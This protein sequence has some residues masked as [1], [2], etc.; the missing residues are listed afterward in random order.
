MTNEPKWGYAPIPGE[1]SWPVTLMLVV[2]MLCTIG[3]VVAAIAGAGAPT[4]W[5]L[6]ILNV[7]ALAALVIL[8][9]QRRKY[10][11]RLA[12]GE[13]QKREPWSGADNLPSI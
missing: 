9:V 5:V 13:I 11:Q 12:T 10:L 1:K 6:V 3:I 7:A 2:W 8:G 4:L